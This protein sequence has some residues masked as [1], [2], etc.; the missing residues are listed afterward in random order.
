MASL[1]ALERR[2]LALEARLAEVEG[3]HGNT[4]YKLRCASAKSE[5]Q[6]G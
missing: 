4:L 6:N 1:Q 3:G 2:V 5:S